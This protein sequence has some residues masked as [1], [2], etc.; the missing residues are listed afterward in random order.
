[1]TSWELNVAWSYV[2]FRQPCWDSTSL[3]ELE[4]MD[5]RMKPTVGMIH[6][7]TCVYVNNVVVDGQ[8]ELRSWLKQF[9]CPIYKSVSIQKL[10]SPQN[11]LPIH[12]GING[13]LNAP[14]QVCIQ[15]RRNQGP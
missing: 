14:L 5:V 10:L 15:L 7:D 6:A 2:C 13:L 9:A 1:M 8:Y 11:D 3:S 4:L 12:R